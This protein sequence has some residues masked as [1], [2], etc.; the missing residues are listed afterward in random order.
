LSKPVFGKKRRQRNQLRT[1]IVVCDDSGGKILQ[2][3]PGRIGPAI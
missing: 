2:E 3:I 1:A